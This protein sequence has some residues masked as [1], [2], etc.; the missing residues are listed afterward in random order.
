MDGQPTKSGTPS[1]ERGKSE[2][3]DEA[4]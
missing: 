1:S 4:T 3:G 2:K